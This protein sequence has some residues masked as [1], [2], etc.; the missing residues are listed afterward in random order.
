[1]ALDETV[2]DF[3]CSSSL[4]QKKPLAF[5]QSAVQ[6]SGGMLNLVDSRPPETISSRLRKLETSLP[7]SGV[8]ASVSGW[9]SMNLRN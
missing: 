1:V 8:L 4:A 5:W 7:S 2:V 3:P 9:N 6:K